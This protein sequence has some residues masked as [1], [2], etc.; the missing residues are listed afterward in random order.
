MCFAEKKGL[1]GA[2]ASDVSADSINFSSKHFTFELMG[3][4]YNGLQGGGGASNICNPTVGCNVCTICCRSYLTNQFDCN[5][6]V[7]LKCSDS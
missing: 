3:A 4:I 2:Y 6:C 7:I 1:G 5:A